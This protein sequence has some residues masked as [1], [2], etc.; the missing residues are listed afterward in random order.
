MAGPMA[1]PTAVIATMAASA[2]LDVL[3]DASLPFE[4]VRRA[5]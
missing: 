1:N 2:F 4:L 3:M 5:F